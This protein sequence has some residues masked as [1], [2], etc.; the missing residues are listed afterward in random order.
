MATGTALCAE[1][2][3]VQQAAESVAAANV[4]VAWR[5]A[6]RDRLQDRRLLAECAVGSVGVVMGD[7]LVQHALEMPLR[8]DQ[9][10]VE[11]FAP[12]TADPAFGVRVGERRRLRSISRL[13][14]DSFA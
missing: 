10:S 13:S 12:G 5:G 6:D 7:V 2:V 1:F 4:S 8:D 3:F 9:D 14:S 11:T